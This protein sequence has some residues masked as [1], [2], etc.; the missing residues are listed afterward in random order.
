MIYQLTLNAAIIAGPLILLAGCSQPSS[1]APQV[2]QPVHED[3][4]HI[5]IDRLQRRVRATG[6]A[7]RIV[8]L[9]PATTEL[10]FALDLGD[11]VVGATK[12]CN[13]PQQALSIPRVGGGTLE[14]IS[15]E[16]IVSLKPDLVLCK[17]DS[18]Q[19]LLETLDRLGIR[20]CAVGAQSLDELYEET[21]WIGRLA[22]RSEE[23]DQLISQMRSRHAELLSV[24][25]AHKKNPPLS[26]FYEVWDEPLM[27]AA[28][29]SFIGELLSMAGL[30]N[31]LA[32]TSVRYPRISSESVIEGNPDLILAPTS[33][34]ENVDIGSFRSRP[35]WS[36]ISAVANER[37]YLISGDEVSRCG[38]RLLDALLE[39]ILAAYPD[40]TNSIQSEPT[41]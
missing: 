28:P 34:F 18:H 7:Q 3:Q 11:E 32:D 13:Y 19:P 38:P 30:E 21:Q 29:N 24:V 12:H 4:Q 16:S 17:W 31:I 10:L 40:A 14:S 33:H 22:Q 6:T 5:V 25:D 37:I 41:R 1:T 15:S 2:Q 23:A 26:V 35:G 36:S 39:I 8:S 27:T 20:V 9:S